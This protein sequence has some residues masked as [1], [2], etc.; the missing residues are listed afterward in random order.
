[1]SAV[2]LIPGAP[3]DKSPG[4]L[5]ASARGEAAEPGVQRAGAGRATPRSRGRGAARAGRGERGTPGRFG[6]GAA[7]RGAS[8]PPLLWAWA[9][10][11]K[12]PRRLR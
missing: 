11:A 2:A 8:R 12:G 5:R 10:G 6:V 3:L 1:M 9:A 7:D 4:R